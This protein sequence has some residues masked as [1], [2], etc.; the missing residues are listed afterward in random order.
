MARASHQTSSRATRHGLTRLVTLAILFAV[1]WASVSVAQYYHP[2]AMYIFPAGGQ[3][4]TTVNVRVGGQF[5]LGEAS[6]GMSGPGVE[7][8]DRI[9]EIDTVWFEGPLVRRP[10][11]LKGDDYPSDHAGEVTI[12]ATAPLGDRYWRVWTAQGATPARR[13]VVGDL[14]EI[15]E[16]EADGAPLPE[17]IELPVTVNGRIFPRED[18]DV[19]TFDAR[20][21]E[22]YNIEVSAARLESPLDARLVVLDPEG[23]KIAEETSGTNR[24]PFLNLIATVDGVYQIHLSDVK[25]NGAQSYVYRLTVSRGVHV[26]W[27]YPLGGQRGGE[28][29][30]ELGTETAGARRTEARTVR[31]PPTGSSDY[32]YRLERDGAYSNTV[33]LQLGDA[34]ERLEVETAEVQCVENAAAPP[35]TLNGRVGAP[36]DMDAWAFEARKG[37]PVIIDLDAAELGS[38]L[39]SVITVVAAD[40][41][42][43]ARADDTGGNTDSQL[44]FDPPADGVYQV[45]V[46]ERFRSRGGPAFAYRLHL[47]SLERPDFELTLPQDALSLKRGGKGSVA[48]TARRMGRTKDPIELI[49]DNLPP[50]VTAESV[51]IPADKNSASIPLVADDTAAIRG[52]ALRVRGRVDLGGIRVERTAMKPGRRGELPIEDVLVAVTLSTPFEIHRTGP[53]Y[54][55]APRGC[56]VTEPFR[57]KRNGYEGPLTIRLAEKQRRHLQGVTAKPLVVP[58]G[59][60]EFEYTVQL[61]PLMEIARTGRVLIVAIGEIEEPD[62]TK[63]RVAFSNTESPQLVLSVTSGRLNVSLD[64]PSVVL[65]PNSQVTLNAKVGRAP[66]LDSPVTVELIVPSHMSGLS[67]APVDVAASESSARLVLRAAE[68]A[69]PFNMPLTIRATARDENGDP[70]YG[71]ATIDIVWSSEL[72][73]AVA[74][75]GAE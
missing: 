52:S 15:V 39:D 24:D 18:V 37:A 47:R 17:K 53:Y 59:V 9:H 43:L 50:G 26:A 7:A 49:V 55:R 45:R 27:N 74:G 32:G 58:A 70:I 36:G 61:R 64:R 63:H 2:A 5:L 23:S 22:S 54:S 69:G 3:R 10:L 12:H 51:V 57:I 35:V 60:D 4:G 42:E 28:L 20:A 67:A 34:P 14:P 38:P 6:F 1:C 21:G 66:D 29:A 11:S 72:P 75:T 56:A 25:Y 71:D 8:R 48:V 33:F 65:S 62:G 16:A 46:A 73:A 68:L 19:W 13:F 44:E 40:G 31:L 41:S 30:L